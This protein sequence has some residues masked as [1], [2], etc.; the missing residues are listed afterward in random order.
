MPP[1]MPTIPIESGVP[2]PDEF[3]LP[4][5]LRPFSQMIGTYRNMPTVQLESVTIRDLDHPEG[6]VIDED[7][8]SWS[9]VYYCAHDNL[10]HVGRCINVGQ[11]KY[12]NPNLTAA[13]SMNVVTAVSS[14]VFLTGEITFA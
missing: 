12:F 2:L 9:D 3:Y 7:S 14:V 13:D 6:L 11:L 8:P 4:E 10:P 1:P 5:I